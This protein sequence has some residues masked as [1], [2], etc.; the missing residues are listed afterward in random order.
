V[1]G[2]VTLTFGTSVSKSAEDG[3][4]KMIQHGF[5]ALRVA[6]LVG[7]ILIIIGACIL[8]L[9]LWKAGSI[10]L[11]VAFAGIA[12]IHVDLLLIGFRGNPFDQVQRRGLAIAATALPPIVVRAAYLVMIQF[13]Q[14]EK[15]SPILGDPA[16]LIGMVLAME[17]LVMSS[18][19]TATVVSEQ[20]LGGATKEPVSEDGN[21]QTLEKAQARHV[22][23]RIGANV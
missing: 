8:F 1:I 14:D 16:Y 10:V 13:D 3:K 17:V 11:T 23:G 15:Y 2:D 6:L 12:A 18:L 9:P 5:I 4:L 19:L 22:A 7:V 21:R 20:L